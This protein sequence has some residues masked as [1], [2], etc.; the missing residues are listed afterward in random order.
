MQAMTSDDSGSTEDHGD[1]PGPSGYVVTPSGDTTYDLY[2]G[3]ISFEYAGVDL[4]Y[5]KTRS[6]NAYL[7]QQ[8]TG[9]NVTLGTDLSGAPGDETHSHHS[10]RV[11]RELRD[12]VLPVND[13]RKGQRSPTSA[14]PAQCAPA[15]VY[16]IETQVNPNSPLGDTLYVP[17]FVAAAPCESFESTQQRSKADHKGRC[18]CH[19]SLTARCLRSLIAFHG[20]LLHCRHASNIT[21]ALAQSVRVCF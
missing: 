7:V 4:S 9:L 18:G 21:S 11:P 3:R 6:V 2:A 19:A 10:F 5:T 14:A 20:H 12:D 13:L 16:V 15:E 17:P 1:G 8:S